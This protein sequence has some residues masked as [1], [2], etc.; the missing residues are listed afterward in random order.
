MLK[1]EGNKSIAKVT[2]CCY[3]FVGAGLYFHILT[4][5]KKIKDNF[6]WWNFFI[7]YFSLFALPTSPPPPSPCCIWLLSSKTTQCFFFFSRH[8]TGWWD[9]SSVAP[10]TNRK[11]QAVATWQTES[12]D[13]SALSVTSY[14]FFSKSLFL[15]CPLFFSD[16]FPTSL[17]CRL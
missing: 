4:K 2:Q 17:S 7:F 13:G 6:S 1:W 12:H 11:A 5:R 16:H 3:S 10:R 15:M 14:M 9:T 8:T